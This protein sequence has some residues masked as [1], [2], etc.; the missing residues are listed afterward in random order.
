MNTTLAAGFERMDGQLWWRHLFQKTAL[1]LKTR[2]WKLYYVKGE[3]VSETRMRT[4]YETAEGGGGSQLTRTIVSLVLKAGGRAS[5]FMAARP[6][7]V[8]VHVH[9]MVPQ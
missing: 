6:D 3:G 2:L 7:H 8:H 9:H 4:M 5:V 1:L